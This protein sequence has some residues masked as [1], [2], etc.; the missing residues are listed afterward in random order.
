M[1]GTFTQIYIH[2]VFGVKY[3]QPLL[4]PEWQ[5]ELN[6]YI[7]G[8]LKNKGQRPII[9]NGYLDHIHVFFAYKPSTSLS[10]LVRDIKANSSR[11]INEEKMNH[12]SG[13]KWQ[14]GY[15][16]FSYSSSAVK[17]VYRYIENQEEHHVRKSFLKEYQE[18]LQMFEV[19]YDLKYLLD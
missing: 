17:N 8:I 6:S 15:G 1:A 7:V 3:R 19:K 12:K 14:I 16:A 4:E 13:F 5:K 9:V 2:V 10:D 11:F 18:L